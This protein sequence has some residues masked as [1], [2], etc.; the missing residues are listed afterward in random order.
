LRNIYGRLLKWCDE[1]CAALRHVRRRSQRTLS[2][3]W[4]NRPFGA[5]RLQAPP[6]FIASGRGCRAGKGVSCALFRI[7]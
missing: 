5:V 4:R 3:T 1:I 2:R 6:E 7:P